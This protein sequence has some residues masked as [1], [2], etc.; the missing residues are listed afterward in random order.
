[1]S[2]NS[3]SY[4]SSSRDLGSIVAD[5][6]ELA[7]SGCQSKFGSRH[8]GG[9]CDEANQARN[10]CK[11]LLNA[12]FSVGRPKDQLVRNLAK[13]VKSHNSTPVWRRPAAETLLMASAEE[14]EQQQLVLPGKARKQLQSKCIALVIAFTPLDIVETRKRQALEFFSF[15]IA[16][17]LG[18]SARMSST[19]LHPLV[20][21][22]G[23]FS[24]D[25]LNVGV[26]ESP[27][28]IIKNLDHHF[29]ATDWL[30]KIIH[31]HVEFIAWRCSIM[32]GD[33]RLVAADR[34]R[35]LSWQGLC[36]ECHNLLFGALILLPHSTG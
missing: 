4:L 32:H 13:L 7:S 27:R 14:E 10:L 36:L 15:A 1:M 33:L 34:L 30:A 3:Y 22:Q 35:F 8:S 12:A 19:S 18:L 17:D 21:H 31:S 9:T 24:Y 2:L 5:C 6:V 25:Y 11:Y 16:C 26:W 23:H 29:L 20:H 28:S